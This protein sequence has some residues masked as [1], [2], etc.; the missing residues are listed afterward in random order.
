MKSRLLL[1]GAALAL[2][3]G[4]LTIFLVARPVEATQKT[5]R[6]VLVVTVT[7]GFRHDSIPT[8]E[9]VLERLGKET[10]SW[11]T[12]FARN[13]EDLQKKMTAE[14]LK[15][16]DAIIFANT[17][18]VLPLPDPNAFLE[19]IRSGRGFVAMHSGSDTFHEW[20][21]STSPVSE[22]IQMLGGEFRTHHAQCAVDC[23]VRDPNHPAVGFLIHDKTLPQSDDLK[24]RSSADGKT[25]QV[26]DEIYL[27]KNIDR[28]ALRVLLS[29]DSH[30]KD[31]SSDAG[32]PGEYLI[33]WCKSYGKGRVFYTSLGHRKEVWN[34]PIYQRH[35]TG[36][37]RFAL[38]LAKGSTT[39]N[40]PKP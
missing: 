36:G 21:G 40:P 14:A 39:P 4:M 34:D 19:F 7:K 2:A 17:T 18:G 20:P 10:K 33:S 29:L 5:K 8:A 15:Q 12:D 1:M 37:I 30:P 23:Q 11:E 26:F 13:D 28:P 38:G 25:W 35:I 32:K 22:Y 24:A 9:E 27:F 6:R 3:A 31:G 16:Y